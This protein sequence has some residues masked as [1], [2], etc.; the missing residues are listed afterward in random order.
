MARYG[1]PFRKK[2]NAGK[3]T[4]GT[5]IRYKYVGGTRVGTVRAS[6]PR[7]RRSHYRKPKRTYH[8]QHA[9]R[10]SSWGKYW[11]R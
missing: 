1:K 5:W 4:K 8:R 10:R 7:Y 6:P 9:W 11:R 2:S 3:Y